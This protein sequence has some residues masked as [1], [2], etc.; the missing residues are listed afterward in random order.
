MSLNRAIALLLVLA[1]VLLVVLEV[2][3]ET[4]DERRPSTWRMFL[5]GALTAAVLLA[6]VATLSLFKSVAGS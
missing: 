3:R 4:G 1:A 5:S 2:S 6:L